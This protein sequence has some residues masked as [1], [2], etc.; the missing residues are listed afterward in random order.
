MTMPGHMAVKGI[1]Q[2][3]NISHRRTG[4]LCKGSADGAATNV[5]L[6]AFVFWRNLRKGDELRNRSYNA[7]H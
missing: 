7:V 1:V 3:T 5:Q 2:S 4:R 6:N